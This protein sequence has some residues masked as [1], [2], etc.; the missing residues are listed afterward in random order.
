MEFRAIR[1]AWP[2]GRPHA[3]PP[4][5]R[6]AIS[7]PSSATTRAPARPYVRGFVA[8][9]GRELG[10]DS[11]RCAITLLRT[12]PP[13]PE[14]VMSAA[15]TS[16]EPPP[17]TWGIA[18]LVLVLLGIPAFNN[19]DQGRA[20]ATRGRRHDRASPGAPAATAAAPAAAAP[21]RPTRAQCGESWRFRRLDDLR[22][23]V[24]ATA[25]ADGARVSLQDN[26][27][28]LEQ[29]LKASR[30]S[31]S[32]CDAGAVAWTVNGQTGIARR[33]R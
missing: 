6:S 28:R 1:I 32:G 29:V 7:K 26:G 24:L 25:S 22:A 23:A 21:R 3:P 30:K 10:L 15:V 17:R 27:A 33:A 8:A 19:G 9:Y 2:D 31:P 16:G 12:R 18:V 5:S 11:G 14:P 4:E 13:P 20:A